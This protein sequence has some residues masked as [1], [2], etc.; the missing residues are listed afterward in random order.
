MLTK[1]KVEKFL[2]ENSDP[3]DFIQQEKIRRYVNLRILF[4]KLDAA[5]REYD[6]VIEVKNGKQS[7]IKINPA[8]TEKEKINVQLLAL[9]RD[10][11]L[12][13]PKDDDPSKLP[14]KTTV[15]D[16]EESLA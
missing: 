5:I 4:D 14:P 3:E 6:A 9:E 7:Y 12:I 8:V 11:K 13:L 10:F 16:E 2:L 1:S 15:E